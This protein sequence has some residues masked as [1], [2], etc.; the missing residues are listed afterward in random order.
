MRGLGPRVRVLGPGPESGGQAVDVRAARRG[1]SGRGRARDHVGRAG[2]HL[3]APVDRRRRR[4]R[5]E[6]H[7][8][9]HRLVVAPP[10]GLHL[11]APLPGEVPDRLCPGRPARSGVELRRPGR[12]A[13]GSVPHQLGVE[14]HPEAQGQHVGDGPGVLQVVAVRPV[15]GEHAGRAALAGVLSSWVD[16]VAVCVDRGA[17]V[18]IGRLAARLCDLAPRSS[19][20]VRGHLEGIEAPTGP[21]NARAQEPAP[22]PP[23]RTAVV[24]PG[25]VVLGVVD[26]DAALQHVLAG[27]VEEHG[28]RRR[29]GEAARDAVFVTPNSAG[30]VEL[31]V[32]S[33]RGPD[34]RLEALVRAGARDR[35]VEVLEWLNGAPVD[36]RSRRLVDAVHDLRPGVPRRV[37]PTQVRLEEQ[38]LVEELS[39]IPEHDVGGVV[40]DLRVAGRRGRVHD[41]PSPVTRGLRIRAQEQVVVLVHQPGELPHGVDPAEPCPVD[42]LGPRDPLHH[43][44]PVRIELGDAGVLLARDPAAVEARANAVV[45]LCRQASVEPQAVLHDRS[46][47][48]QAEVALVSALVGG[49]VGRDGFP[50]PA[51]HLAGGCEQARREVAPDRAVELVGARLDHRVDDAAG[52]V[53][54]LRQESARLHV[55]LVDEVG[56]QVGADVV[57]A[58]V[59]HPEAVEH[60][61]VLGRRRTGQADATHVPQRRGSDDDR[62]L[63]V[64]GRR[65]GGQEVPGDDRTRLGI[66]HV[67]GGSH[68]AVS[69]HLRLEFHRLGS[70]DQVCTKGVIHLEHESGAVGG[71]VA[72]DLGHELVAPGREQREGEVAAGVRHGGLFALEAG[73]GRDDQCP[74]HR[75]PR[76]GVGGSSHQGAGGLAP[77]RACSREQRHARQQSPGSARP[78]P[79]PR[80]IRVHRSP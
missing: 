59:A 26:L 51:D 33:G 31:D 13:R 46:A 48:L 39:A 57:Q 78:H 76:R 45:E 30:V 61:V 35:G 54:V 53:A 36:P 50:V 73:A 32:A 49:G 19:L 27:E 44:H 55:D 25:A 24:A 58:R 63:V 64:A 28:R 18:G 67:H 12:V 79:R 8:E 21:G 34:P 1:I 77:R 74:G 42:E 52:R 37:V 80:R 29:P 7:E 41:A 66:A 75:F 65:D 16:A 38:V 60:V 72:H 56:E 5:H 14:A 3:V 70:E 9:R 68:A 71:Q 43:E 22:C 11:S 17:P 15:A 47:H 62:P 2:G 10:V 20:A 6:S 4:K 69:H 23:E 40:L